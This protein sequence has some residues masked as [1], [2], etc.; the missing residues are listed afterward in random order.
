VPEDGVVFATVGDAALV[1]FVDEV[2]PALVTVGVDDLDGV[3]AV[4]GDDWPVV[5]F[6]VLALTAGVV[7]VVDAWVRATVGVAA[8]WVAAGWASV[9]WLDAGAV[10]FVGAVLLAGSLL[11]SLLELMMVPRVLVTG[12]VT[13][14][15]TPETADARPDSGSGSPPV[16]A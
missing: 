2:D 5:S 11:D 7:C 12:S 6:A 3:A 14:W 9:G 16:A 8:A 4:A 10:L 15:T 1:A 13:A